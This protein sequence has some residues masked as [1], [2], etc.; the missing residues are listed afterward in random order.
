MVDQMPMPALISTPANTTVAGYLLRRLREHG[1]DHLF[2]VPG[3]FALSFF[4]HVATTDMT[5]VNTCDEQGAGFAADAYARVRGLGAVCVT[6]GVGGLK[7]AN[8]T[9]QAM[10]EEVPV[11]VISGAPSLHQ[12]A[13]QQLLH[14][15]INGFDNQHRVFEH[16]TVATAV[17][18]D[19]S[20]ACREI[21]RVLDAAL[22]F[23]RPVY[24]EI[25]RDMTLAEIVPSAPV[26][27]PPTRVRDEA[28]LAAAVADAVSM[29]SAAAQPAVFVGLEPVRL[30]LLEQTR[31][32]IERHS[33]PA[34]VT[35]LSKSAISE[36]HPCFAG[37]YGGAMSRQPVREYVES[38]DCL[39]MLGSLLS[40]LSLG[41]DTA[42]LPVERMI[43]VG[44][45]RVRIAHRTYEHVA[46]ADFLAALSQAGL[47]GYGNVVKPEPP[48]PAEPW[49]PAP[50]ATITVARLFER[51]ASFVDDETVVIADPGDATFGALDLPVRQDFEF[52]A[53]AFYA[54]LGFAIPA[55][56]GAQLAAPGRRPLVLVGDGAFQ[57][58]GVE[59]ST[60]LRYGLN[61]IV[62][63][64]N[65]EGYLTERLLTDGPFNDVLSWRYAALP[66]LFGAGRS[67]EVSTEE[68]LETALT[69]ARASNDLCIIEVHLARLDASPALKRLAD[70]L[71]AQARGVTPGP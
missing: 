4:E 45:D 34:F 57:M 64:L 48:V 70:G 33:L 58:T 50:A 53:N 16:L 20:L 19:P 55:S 69:A 8:S 39:L 37:V 42:H 12:R 21:D 5:I 41:G 14:H 59:L 23:K 54:S 1:V 25:P 51:L 6:Y 11:V 61:P 28:T 62:V 49:T 29:L 2:G 18:D 60:S 9:A 10:A 26:P 68:D 24:I 30:G 65:N 3:D 31:Q 52:L 17:I 38:A 71:N 13:S 36:Q 46:F 56:I 67:F 40:D 66:Q 27:V 22:T 44:R 43:L 47:P 32:F 63:I 15:V 7:I 35:L